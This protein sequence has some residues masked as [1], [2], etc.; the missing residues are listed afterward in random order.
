MNTCSGTSWPP[1]IL[2]LVGPLSR[3]FRQ[4]L[5]VTGTAAVFDIHPI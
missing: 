3:Q 4:R 5:G 2:L 1:G